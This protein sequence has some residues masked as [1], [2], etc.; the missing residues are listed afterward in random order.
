[1]G[2][3]RSRDSDAGWLLNLRRFHDAGLEE[4]KGEPSR[5]TPG[6]TDTTRKEHVDYTES[7]LAS[8]C[9]HGFLLSLQ[10][11]RVILLRE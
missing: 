11:Q 3:H 10:N 8:M 9:H 6:Y 2:L 5:C 4:V 7:L 1:M